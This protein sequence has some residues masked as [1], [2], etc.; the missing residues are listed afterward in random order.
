V[1]GQ[2]MA[3]VLGGALIAGVF[4][5]RGSIPSQITRQDRELGGHVR[6]T[7]SAAVLCLL[8]AF[9][10]VVE[11]GVQQWSS[12][13]LADIVRAPVGLSAAAPG[14]FAGALALGRPGLPGLSGCASDRTVLLSA[15]VL[16][17]IGV[18][19]LTTAETPAHGLFGTAVVGVAISV[20][21]PTAYG[22][23]GRGV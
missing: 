10:M 7:R 23:I 13:F 15:G 16:S 19:L 14:F 2:I 21:T 18:L 9:A 12:V 4:A 22:L 20:A 1:S 5:A 8:A 6:L 11:S 17:G 3:M